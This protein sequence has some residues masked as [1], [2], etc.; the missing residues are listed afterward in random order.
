MKQGKEQKDLIE[1]GYAKVA[2]LYDDYKYTKELEVL[3]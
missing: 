1:K 2:Y 3:N